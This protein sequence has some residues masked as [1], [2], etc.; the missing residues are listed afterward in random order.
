MPDISIKKPLIVVIILLYCFV[1]ICNFLTP[2]QADDFIYHYRFDNGERIEHI[3]DII[4]SLV[5]HAK[6][7]NGRTTAH[8]FVHLFE[9]LPKTLFNFIN[10]AV[11][12]SLLFIMHKFILSLRSKISI[13]MLLLIFLSVWVFTPAFGEVFLWLDG[14]VNYL[15]AIVLN[16]L[17]LSPYC[18]LF[19]GA[20]D[21]FNNFKAHKY[22][23]LF[24][25][26]CYILLSFLAGSFQETMS[27]ASFMISIAFML[28]THFY[29]KKKVN[30]IYKVAS[31]AFFCGLLFMAIQPAE[32]SVKSSTTSFVTIFHSFLTMMERFEDSWILI[33]MF[34]ICFTICLLK[35][36]DPKQLILSGIFM[37]GFICSNGVMIFAKIYPSRCAS[38]SIVL[39]LIAD[40]QLLV[41]IYKLGLKKH[42]ICISV[43]LCVSALYFVIIG[44]SDIVSTF[45]QFKANET[46]IIS[47]RENNIQEIYLPEL[48]GCTKY[49]VAYDMIFPSPIDWVNSSMC[50]YYGV[51]HIVGYDE[52]SEYFSD[53]SSPS[54]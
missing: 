43:L 21:S 47:S 2:Y 54:N 18:A 30:L 45:I 13:F 36:C 5:T 20:K 34:F 50:K 1:L 51:E 15:W 35:H 29:D 40:W 27:S 3:S 32:I 26:L 10:S 33:F 49:S 39:I 22:A 23:V 37:F 41:Q 4:P 24:L 17:F 16:L 12:I 28:F 31:I 44:T 48:H 25:Q 46:T 11:F 8:F 38:P 7:I 9:M 52:Y 53:V 14:S 19:M 6:A 42:V